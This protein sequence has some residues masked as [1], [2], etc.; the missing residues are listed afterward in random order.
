MSRT[1]SRQRVF[2][3]TGAVV[4]GLVIGLL[5]VATLTG[6]RQA[7]TYRPFFAGMKDDRVRNI[8]EGGPVLIPDPKGGDRSFYLDLNGNEVVAFHVI[9]PGG[10]VRCLVQY[11]HGQRRYEDCKGEAVEPQT[12][13]RFLVTTRTNDK[14]EQAI[15][16]DVRELL[17]PSGG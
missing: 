14:D 16:V 9:P 10:N 2:V 12:L 7:P 8:R 15:F 13:G 1:G 6:T 11:D 5:V 4:G 17:P 3:L